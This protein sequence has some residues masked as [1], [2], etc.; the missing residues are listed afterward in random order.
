MMEI[1][2]YELIDFGEN[3]KLESFAGTIVRR[4]TPSAIGDRSLNE[5]WHT[6]DLR[7][8]QAGD[9]IQ[10]QGAAPD[11]WW[12]DAGRFRLMLRTTPTGQIGVFPEQAI[13]WNWIAQVPLELAGLRAINLFAYTGATTMALAD[14]GASVV[15]VD[16]AKSVVNWAR[17]NAQ[18]SGLA[19][20]PIR[21]IVEDAMTFVQRELKRGNTYDIVIA[22]PPSFGRGPNGK[23]WKIQRDINQLIESLSLLTAGNCQMMLLSCHT[24]G[25]DHLALE[26]STHRVFNWEPGRAQA[27]EMSLKSSSG[28]RLPSGSC[29]RWVA[30]SAGSNLES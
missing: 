17:S 20:A 18:E 4:E 6:F 30:E 12:L 2:Q 24:P 29:L 10:W 26:R 1:E 11:P 8:K 3:E 7:G 16:A 21:W 25:V 19:Q 23:H 22:D 5:Q 9:G 28:K 13:N 14:R 15:H 27:F